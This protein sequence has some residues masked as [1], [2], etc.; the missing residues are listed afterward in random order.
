MLSDIPWVTVVVPIV[1]LTL[2]VLTFVLRLMGDPKPLSPANVRKPFRFVKRKYA[3]HQ[4]A[5][6]QRYAE[7]AKLAE[8]EEQRAAFS[9]LEASVDQ[10]RLME[11][12]WVKYH[13][14]EWKR[15]IH[16]CK[17]RTVRYL[18]LIGVQIAKDRFSTGPLLRQSKNG[19]IIIT[20]GTTKWNRGKVQIVLDWHPSSPLTQ[21]EFIKF[22]FADEP[23][24]HVT[25]F[26]RPLTDAEMNAVGWEYPDRWNE[27]FDER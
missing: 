22:Y 8:R 6:A 3:E 1:L 14:V 20:W 19:T 21:D 18:S 12:G 26:S 7:R 5:T 2:A 23:R 4:A 17:E 9:V 24:E 16:D 11:Q 13:K 27:E 15:Q 10:L 25:V